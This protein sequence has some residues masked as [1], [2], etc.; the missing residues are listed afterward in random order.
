MIVEFIPKQEQKP[1][2]GQ[3]F[4]VIVSIVLVVGIAFSIFLLQQSVRSAREEF[5]V[6]NKTFVEEI[7]PL[8]EELSAK[9]QGYKGKTEVLKSVLDEKKN[10]LAFLTLL[11]QTTH[12][13]IFFKSLKGNMKTGVFE[14]EG[15][16]ENF[17]VLEQQRLIWNNQEEFQS[18]LQ[19][20]RLSEEG[21]AEFMVEFIV[22]PEILNPT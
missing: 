1:I 7:R 15:E 11:E 4:F 6:L 19:N 13:G 22:A 5:A 8:E 14:L 16:A 12:S 20:I 18:E 21:A 10:V 17:L 2:F 9:L 3:M